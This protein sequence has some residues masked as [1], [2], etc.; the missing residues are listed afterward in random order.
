M[1]CFRGNRL[2]GDRQLKLAVISSDGG[3]AV[4]AVWEIDTE[5]TFA[6]AELRRTMD[7]KRPAILT[8]SL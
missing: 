5:E 4:R 6:I 7:L 1:V 8:C 2:V 3:W